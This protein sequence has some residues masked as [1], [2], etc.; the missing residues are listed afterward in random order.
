MFG[1]RERR[2]GGGAQ[3]VATEAGSEQ[4]VAAAVLGDA[5]CAE[6]RRR[7]LAGSRTG[8]GACSDSEGG[9]SRGDANR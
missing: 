7:L 4:V 8:R 5:Q 9:T 2:R 1:I 3:S 6:H